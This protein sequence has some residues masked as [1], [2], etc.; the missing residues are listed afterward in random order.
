MVIA[1]VHP[2]GLPLTQY[3]ALLAATNCRLNFDSKTAQLEVVDIPKSIKKAV[4]AALVD[5]ARFENTA[6]FADGMSAIHLAELIDF[7]PNPLDIDL[8]QRVL[9]ALGI[10][11]DGKFV[12]QVIAQQKTNRSWHLSEKPSECTYFGD[13]C[14][15][16]GIQTVPGKR[17]RKSNRTPEQYHILSKSGEIAREQLVTPALENLVNHIPADNVISITTSNGFV[18]GINLD[19]LDETEIQKLVE[20]IKEIKAAR[21]TEGVAVKV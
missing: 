5:I 10:T 11:K 16:R 14:T 12:A 20:H 19:E 2:P 18:G 4:D 6:N 7:N 17:G 8:R 21:S 1:V 3:G 9:S 13:I 15:H